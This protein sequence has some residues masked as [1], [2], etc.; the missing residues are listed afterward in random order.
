MIEKV[1][2]VGIVVVVTA[3]MLATVLPRLLPAITTLGVLGIAARVVW[4]YTR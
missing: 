4:W 3:S 2:A 1:I